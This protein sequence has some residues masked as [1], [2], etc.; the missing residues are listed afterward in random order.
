MKLEWQ[1]PRAEERG[2]KS[3]NNQYSVCSITIDGHE[4][5]Q[6]WKLAPQAAWFAPL[7]TGLAD[8][9]SAREIAQADAD[10]KP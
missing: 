6:A 7:A 3:T 2:Y 4:T 8:E 10:L 5:W 9:A 1:S